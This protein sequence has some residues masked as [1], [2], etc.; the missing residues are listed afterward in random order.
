MADTGSTGNGPEALVL[1]SICGAA[2]H[3]M[4]NGLLRCGLHLPSNEYP[5][6]AEEA[7]SLK[8]RD[9]STAPAVDPEDAP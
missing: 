9:D 6:S 4:N 7:E 1:C 5:L 3:P 2:T 8:T